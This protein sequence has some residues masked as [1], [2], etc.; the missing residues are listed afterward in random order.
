MSEKSIRIKLIL[1][2]TRRRYETATDFDRGEEMSKEK[3]VRPIR[4]GQTNMN[5]REASSIDKDKE[6]WR[7]TLISTE[8]GLTH[9]RRRAE[10][11]IEID[12]GEEENK[13]GQIS[14]YPI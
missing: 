8:S 11:V 7:K 9:R 13:S 5:R 14:N 3:T 2:H 6:E 4:K 10:I 12:R 1:I